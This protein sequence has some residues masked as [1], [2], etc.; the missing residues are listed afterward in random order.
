MTMLNPYFSLYQYPL[1]TMIILGVL[2]IWS[3]IWN[4]FGLWHAARNKQL[5]WFIAIMV[6]NS[7]GLL[8]IIY[9][10]WFRPKKETAVK[11]VKKK[12]K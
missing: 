11:L 10:L 7:A 9:L 4:G 2:I 12:K 3:V 8:P 6:I 1:W 5:G